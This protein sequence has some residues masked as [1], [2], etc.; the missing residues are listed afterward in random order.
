[1]NKNEK[2]F[3]IGMLFFSMLIVSI[4]FSFRG[5]FIPTFKE[6]FNISNKAIGIFLS[7]IQLTSMGTY[8]IGIKLNEKFGQKKIMTLGLGVNMLS[9]IAISF[10]QSFIH[11]TIGYIFI[12]FATSI[13]LLSI[14][15]TIP[16][17][18]VA[19]QSTLLNLVHGFFGVGN[20]FSQKIVG[21]LIENGFTWEIIYR[22]ISVGFLVAFILYLFAYDVKGDDYNNKG[23]QVIRDKKKLILFIFALGFY[24]SAEIQTGNWFMNLLKIEYAY[25]A[26][27]ATTFTAI[28]F[29]T[30]TFGR[31]VGGFITEKLGYFKSI[32]YTS[33]LTVITYTIGLLLKENG[34]YLI[35]F[36][37]LFLAIVFPTTMALIGKVFKETASKAIA[38]TSTSIAI[39]VLFSGLIIG[40]LN[41]FI[42]AYLA[43]YM[44]PIY[45]LI[46]LLFFLKLN[47]LVNKENK[48]SEII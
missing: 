20:T 43:F 41:D 47:N 40:F 16:L 1:M 10:A 4:S 37:G 5:I 39:F 25:S 46:S 21:F 15:T 26:S 11:L 28:F 24:V 36:A 38:I 17:I 8:I 19:F 29:G 27:H 42:G 3:L 33:T 34:L 30:F 35:A 31:F 48:K 12:T 2:Y 13:I 14:N 45:A 22:Y 6:E 23:S 9:F 32:I 44:I 7:I 18:H